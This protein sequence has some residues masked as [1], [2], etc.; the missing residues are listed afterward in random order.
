LF[1]IDLPAL[2]EAAQ[3]E[4]IAELDADDLEDGS[5]GEHECTPALGGAPA[6]EVW[7][8]PQ[9]DAE[10]HAGGQAETSANGHPPASSDRIGDRR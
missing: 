4:P 9:A 6:P 5:P 8:A 1:R 2:V 10:T 3:P 7:C